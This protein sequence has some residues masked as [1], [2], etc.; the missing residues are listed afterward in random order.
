VAGNYTITQKTMFYKN[1]AEGKFKE[2][3]L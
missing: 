3:L 2:R 1:A